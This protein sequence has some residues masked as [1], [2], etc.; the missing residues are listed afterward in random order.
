MTS[1]CKDGKA[2]NFCPLQTLVSQCAVE[3]QA[4][5]GV[6]VETP[7]TAFFPEGLQPK[8]WALWGP[9]SSIHF[10]KRLKA[11]PVVAAGIF[12]C[13]PSGAL[14]QGFVAHLLCLSWFSSVPFFP[15]S[16]ASSGRPLRGEEKGCRRAIVALPW[17]TGE[18]SH[19]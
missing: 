10:L 4:S 15:D 18:R 8:L 1:V 9:G 12:T 11:M 3:C 13:V 16:C 14:Q 5:P 6:T 7:A 19:V 17:D 2:A